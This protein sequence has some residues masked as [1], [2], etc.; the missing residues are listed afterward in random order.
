MQKKQFDRITGLGYKDDVAELGKMAV[1]G[2]VAVGVTAVAGK[3]LVGVLGA[4][5]K[6]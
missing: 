5:P 2:V 1:K 4:F 3:T 6:Q